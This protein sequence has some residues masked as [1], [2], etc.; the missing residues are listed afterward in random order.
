MVSWRKD[1]LP[2]YGQPRS[3]DY[4]TYSQFSADD[5]LAGKILVM[6]Q[7][8]ARRYHRACRG[9]TPDAVRI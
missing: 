4:H 8:P 6:P 5:M 3:T 2:R 9:S 1:A 7:L